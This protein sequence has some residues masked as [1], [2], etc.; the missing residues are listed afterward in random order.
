[1]AGVL[2]LRVGLHRTHASWQ[3]LLGVYLLLLVINYIPMLW[4]A[5]D[6]A[7]SGTAA[8]ELGDELHDKSVAMKKYR[9]QSLWLLVPLSAPVSW[10]MQPGSKVR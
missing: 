4:C 7:R 5:I 8:I 9:R 6:I 2:S 10:L 3:I 1:M